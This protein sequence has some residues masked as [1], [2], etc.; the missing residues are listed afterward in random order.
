MNILKTSD[1][2]KFAREKMPGEK[3]T[4][5][6]QDSIT[7]IKEVHESAMQPAGSLKPTEEANQ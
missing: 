6:I 5:D 1:M 2:V 3:V 4:K 7:I